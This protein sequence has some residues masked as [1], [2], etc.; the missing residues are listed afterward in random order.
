MRQGTGN[1][2]SGARVGLQPRVVVALLACLLAYAAGTAVSRTL[3][4]IA[5]CSFVEDEL[6][7]AGWVGDGGPAT[8]AMLINPFN[9]VVDSQGRLL[10]ADASN[11]RVFV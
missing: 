1:G 2:H 3:E 10:I 9:V 6:L 11:N 8:D 5:G 4:T 7:P